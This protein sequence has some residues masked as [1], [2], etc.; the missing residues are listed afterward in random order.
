MCQSH[1][2]RL[3]H[4]CSPQLDF[5]NLQQHVCNLLRLLRLLGQ[6]APVRPLRSCSMPQ[7]LHPLQDQL[8]SL[9]QLLQLLHSLQQQL[10]SP[11]QLLFC[12]RQHLFSPLLCRYLREPSHRPLRPCSLLQ[13]L[14]LRKVRLCSLLQPV[15]LLLNQSHH[16]CVL[17]QLQLRP[18]QH[19]P[20]RLPHH[21]HRPCRSLQRHQP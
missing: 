9:L 13:L 7:Q 17:Q 6:Q 10:C 21:Q 18:R 3:Q 12:Q 5:P 11:Q 1:R 2:N 16:L 15:Q 4:L 14:C 20:L 19:S 8:C